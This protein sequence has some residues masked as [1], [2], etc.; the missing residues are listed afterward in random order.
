[1]Q[2]QFTTD[3]LRAELKRFERQL[4]NASY[5]ESSVTT[6][7]D[8]ASRFLDWIDGTYVPTPRTASQVRQ[9]LNGGLRLQATKSHR[10]GN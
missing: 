8:R 7:V 4:Q 9:Q 5:A 3:Q 10:Q 6:Y 2:P 1:M